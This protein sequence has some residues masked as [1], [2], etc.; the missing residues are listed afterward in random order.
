[1][2]DIDLFSMLHKFRVASFADIKQINL[3]NLLRLLADK[4]ETMFF[5]KIL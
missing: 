4:V 3:E 2:L 1:M 5:T